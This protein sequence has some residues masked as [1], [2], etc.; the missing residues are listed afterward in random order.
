MKSSLSS[1]LP[2]GE[3]E[4]GVCLEGSISIFE[5]PLSCNSEVWDSDFSV[6]D[7]GEAGILMISFCTEVFFA[8]S[9]S[10]DCDADGV[11]TSVLDTWLRKLR[12]SGCGDPVGSILRRTGSDFE[13]D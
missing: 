10:G 5:S 4:E 6:L 8:T 1:A 7:E 3:A 2:A 13:D 12:L 11:S 9:N